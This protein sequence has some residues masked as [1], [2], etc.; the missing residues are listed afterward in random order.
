MVILPN[1]SQMRAIDQ[2]AINHFGI[3]GI[4]L[5]ENAGLGTVLKI[6]QSYGPL[7][8]ACIPIFVGPGNNGGDGLVIAR[9]LLQRKAL[10]QLVFLIEPGQL[11]GDSATNL[12]IVE[13]L[14]LP[15]FICNNPDSVSG[16]IDFLYDAESRFGSSKMFIDAIFGTGLCRTIEGHYRDI[17]DH[18]NTRSRTGNISIVAVD[19]PSGLD[20][21]TGHT[22]GICIEAGMTATY[23]Y[24]KIGQM[25]ANSSRYTG[26]LHIIDIGIPEEV[27]KHVPVSMHSLNTSSC[28]PWLKQLQRSSDTHKGSFGHL[29]VVGG[30]T[31]KTGA[32]IL[33]GRGALRS[34]C[35]LVSL[36]CSKDL[37]PVYESALT[38]M[39]TIPLESSTLFNSAD[40]KPIR[41]HAKDKDAIVLGPGIGQEPST[42]NLVV[43]LYN[44]VPLPMVVDADALNILAA[45]RQELLSPPAARILTPHPGEMARLI[46]TDTASVQRNRIDS[47]HQCLKIF[48]HPLGETIIILKG[49]ATIVGDT[50]RMAVNTSGNPGMAAGGMGDVL[51]GMIGSFICQGITPFDAACFAVFLHGYCGDRLFRDSGIGFS[52]SELADDM[53]RAMLSLQDNCR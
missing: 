51:S 45:H 44:H 31:G 14:N 37:N 9:H 8:D 24:A 53:G 13:K 32:A 39:M 43:E 2:C 19:T 5:M 42:V 11:K 35:G 18:I 20:S 47:V 52:A 7:R 6:E 29:L 30:S 38:E 40:L 36:C 1:A 28:D 16:A 23:G 33:A 34:G 48:T 3:P 26:E 12:A 22:L 27:A 17:I 50:E 21:D 46:D 25:T 4:V 41:N 15:T 49:A 10:P